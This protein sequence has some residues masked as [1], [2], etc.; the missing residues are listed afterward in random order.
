MFRFIYDHFFPTCL[1]MADSRWG[2]PA[3][4]NWIPGKRSS[5]KLR[6]NG[7]SSSIL[8]D[9]CHFIVMTDAFVDADAV[10]W[11]NCLYVRWHSY[12]FGQVHVSQNSHDNSRLCVIRI[13]PF[14]GT[15]SAQNRQNIAQAE[16]IVDLEVKSKHSS[17][18]QK[19]V[20]NVKNH[21][22]AMLSHLKLL[23]IFFHPWFKSSHLY[24]QNIAME[25]VYRLYTGFTGINRKNN[26]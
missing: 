7:S 8:K 20:I 16:V 3:L 9:K 10:M 17:A 1:S 25:I 14:C 22:R 12:Q 26:D 19:K 2:Y 6:N 4:S 15:K 13:S 18:R 5:I 21:Y 24:L 23:K 11:E